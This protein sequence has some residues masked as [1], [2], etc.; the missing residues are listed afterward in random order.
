M[1]IVMLGWAGVVGGIFFLVTFISLHWL[2][3]SIDIA[4]NYV[5][6]YANGTYGRLFQV[7]M[8]MHGIGNLAITGGLAL[9]VNSHAGKW[10][11]R[12]F[13]LA[14]VGIVVASVFATDPQGVPRT[15]TGTIHLVAGFAAFPIEALALVFFAYAFSELP[16]W[17]AFA[18]TTSVTAALSILALLWLLS[19]V[20][21]GLE[22]GLAERASFLIF[23]VWEIL[24]GLRL[25]IRVRGHAESDAMSAGD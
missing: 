20:T 10:A 15:V 7:S 11:T 12:L 2:D 13:G 4:R 8:F 1:L 14:S 21:R 16:S 18:I 5:S 3:P 24:V 23:M 19:V 9:I 6:D 25:A 22:A 17:R